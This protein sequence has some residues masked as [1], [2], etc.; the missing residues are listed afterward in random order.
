MR[1]RPAKASR[2]NLN[3]S[4]PHLFRH[5]RESGHPELAPGLNRGRPVPCPPLWAP[6]FAG[7]T[8]KRK[9]D[10]SVWFLPPVRLLNVARP[11]EKRMKLGPEIEPQFRNRGKQ[12]TDGGIAA[13]IA[14]VETP[15]PRISA[16][17]RCRSLF[18]RCKKQQKQPGASEGLA[19]F[20]RHKSCCAGFNHASRHRRAS[21]A[22]SDRAQRGGSRP[23]TRCRCQR[24]SVWRFGARS[25]GAAAMSRDRG[26]GRRSATVRPF[27]APPRGRT[28]APRRF[29][30]DRS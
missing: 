17:E 24:P 22:W 29:P 19:P 13:V 16:A 11:A 21:R 27:P 5:A 30:R 2:A 12:Q 10:S 28:S 26:S 3:G 15:D 18:L 25:P 9:S 4:Y 23:T 6:G 14:P 20:R 7:A 8:R 1:I